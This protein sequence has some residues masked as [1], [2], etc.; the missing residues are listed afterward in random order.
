MKHVDYLAKKELG[1]S[2]RRGGREEKS[3]T[4]S[5]VWVTMKEPLVEV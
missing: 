5:F 1:S 3:L 4:E 2:T